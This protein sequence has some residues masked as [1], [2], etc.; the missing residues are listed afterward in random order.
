MSDLI[1]K[2]CAWF[3]IIKVAGLSLTG[4]TLAFISNP[5]A[6]VA[7]AVFIA[8]AYKGITYMFEEW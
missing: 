4:L 1:G 7:M 5:V 3:L 6:F 2:I 8:I